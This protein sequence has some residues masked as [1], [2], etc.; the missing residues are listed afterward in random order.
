MGIDVH[1][2]PLKLGVGQFVKPKSQ[3][4][5][6][7]KTESQKKDSHKTNS[8]KSEFEKLISESQKLIDESQK[9]DYKRPL[10]REEADFQRF[11][12]VIRWVVEATNAN[13]KQF[14]R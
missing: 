6:S 7:Q 2:P 10:T 3:K 9:P 13:L 12:T 14:Q 1:V 8:Q 5:D 4:T 11:V